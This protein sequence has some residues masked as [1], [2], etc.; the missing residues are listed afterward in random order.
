MLAS[1]LPTND[2]NG[3]EY[4]YRAAELLITT[5]DGDTAHATP[6]E[7]DASRG[8]IGGWTFQS[9]TTGDVGQ[10]Y[11]TTVTNEL[12]T[13]SVAAVKAWGDHDDH[14][15]YGD[16]PESVEVD[17]YE[18]Y[19]KPGA[20][21][22]TEEPAMRDGQALTATLIKQGAWSASW[23]DLPRYKQGLADVEITYVVRA[24]AEGKQDVPGY[25]V[26]VT[27]AGTH[28]V[29]MEYRQDVV[30]ARRTRR[31]SSPRTAGGAS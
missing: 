12:I 10:G 5:T 17:L 21:A 4:E 6:A 11:T 19:T 24:H 29:G 26:T 30:V 20:A 27:N 14:D 28:K 25:D 7:G 8:T 18:R 23:S 2:E 22:Y 16:R 31:S 15:V 13:G 3:N 9:T 1:G